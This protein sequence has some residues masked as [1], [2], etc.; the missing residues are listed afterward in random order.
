MAKVHVLS[1][2]DNGH[3]DALVHFK[4]SDW[5]LDG[6][7]AA[8]IS[9]KAAALAAGVI[10]NEAHAAADEAEK[11]P[12]LAGDIVEIQ[13][14]IRVNPEGLSSP[15]VTAAVNAEADAAKASWIVEQA[16][17]L[18]YYGYKQGVS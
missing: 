7:N 14:T 16:A 11:A 10:G 13:T 2:T 18:K 9:W 5:S 15:Q 4:T 1:M 6:N 12:I 8:G 3:F 17:R